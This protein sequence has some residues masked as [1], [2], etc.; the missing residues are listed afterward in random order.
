MQ[1]E[2]RAVNDG[3]GVKRKINVEVKASNGRNEVISTDGSRGISSSFMPIEIR[4]KSNPIMLIELN[5]S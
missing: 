3:R 1:A 4:H 5:Q 2:R